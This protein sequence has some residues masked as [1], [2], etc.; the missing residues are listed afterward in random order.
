MRNSLTQPSPA[1]TPKTVLVV[2]DSPLYRRFLR[3]AC[4]EIP[5]IKVVGHASNGENALSQIEFLKPDFVLLD[6]HMPIQG[7]LEVLE[8]LQ[9]CENAPCVIVLTTE[10]ENSIESTSKALALGAFDF[11]LKPNKDSIEQNRIRLTC[12]LRQRFDAYRKMQGGAVSSSRMAP[13]VSSDRTRSTKQSMPARVVV[14]GVSTGGPT[15][16]ATVLSGMPQDYPLPILV[17][18]HMPAAFT[19][20][21]ARDLDEGSPLS[22]R[23]AQDGDL[24]VAGNV[25]IAPGG[26]QM[27]IEASAP[28]PIVRISDEELE[29][30]CSP[31]VNYLLQSVANVYRSGTFVAIMTGMGNDGVDGCERVVEQGG[32]VITQDEPSSIV[33]GMPRRVYEAGLSTKSCPLESISAELRNATTLRI[34]SSPS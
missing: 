6:I 8:Q 4:S 18:Q 34:A 11:V 24:V 27:G 23:E 15:A 13:S 2:D 25:Y 7:G 20:N 16:L 19:R 9:R 3:T 29:N 5:G 31:S 14:I 26:K 1:H 28:Y 22:V 12:K 32:T 21:L 17:V 33:Y 10:S 30:H